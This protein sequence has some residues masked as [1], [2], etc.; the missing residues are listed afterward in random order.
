M[1][2]GSFTL[3]QQKVQ[4]LATARAAQS[5][6]EAKGSPQRSMDISQSTQ[7]AQRSR[8]KP[9]AESSF[10][11]PRI[12]ENPHQFDLDVDEIDDD[13]IEI[14]VPSREPVRKAHQVELS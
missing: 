8:A 11:Q 6:I 13:I 3:N 12:E 7:N 14:G 2:Y 1:L 5:I 4:K 10:I 9:H